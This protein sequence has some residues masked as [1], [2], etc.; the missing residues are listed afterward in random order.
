MSGSALLAGSQFNHATRRPA[1]PTATWC[2]AMGWGPVAET[3][4]WLSVSLGCLKSSSPAPGHCCCFVSQVPKPLFAL[5]HRLQW[6][7][8][9]AILGENHHYLYPSCPIFLAVS[10]AS[11]LRAVGGHWLE[12]AQWWSM[13]RGAG[14]ACHAL[15]TPARGA[16]AMLTGSQQQMILPIWQGCEQGQAL[17]RGSCHRGYLNYLR[18]F[19]YFI[20][21]FFLKP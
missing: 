4:Q 5:K 6:E 7:L 9:V 18:I 16:N 20:F 21:T 13:A 15:R 12:L 17:L 2:A 19:F 3:I 8:R 14:A 11:A 10:K 1:S